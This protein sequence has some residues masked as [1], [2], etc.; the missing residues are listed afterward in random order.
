MRVRVANRHS[1]RFGGVGMVS[2]KQWD[3]SDFWVEVA[4]GKSVALIARRN[5]DAA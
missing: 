1:D 3:G 4:F 2:Q 5:L